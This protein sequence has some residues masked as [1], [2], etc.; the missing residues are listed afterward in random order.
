MDQQKQ[1]QALN[2]EYQG[3]QTELNTIVTARQKLESQYTEN[4]SVQ[5]VAFQP[6]AFKGFCS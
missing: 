3:L 4:K 6:D 5:K 2:D 1:F